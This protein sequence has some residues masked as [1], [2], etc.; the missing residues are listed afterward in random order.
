M[1]RVGV[2]VSGRGSNL[3]ALMAAAREQRLGGEV[4]VVISNVAE[5]PALDKARAA[6]VPALVCDHRGRP[7]E[8]HDRRVLRALQDHGVDLVCL[9]GY[10]RLLSS[11]FLAALPHRV[12]NVHPSLLPAFPGLDAQ[13][14]AWEHGVKVA[15]ATVHL[16]EEAL[17]A[18]PI[19]MQEPVEVRADDSPETLAARILEAEHRIYPRA[20]RL[21]LGGRWHVEGRRFVADAESA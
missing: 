12:V 15:G 3:Q 19:V 11:P 13:R 8:E 18:G 6:G 4:A 2:L 21:L 16:V 17:D 7:R 9:A 5:A 20:V 1:K 14:Q 10:M